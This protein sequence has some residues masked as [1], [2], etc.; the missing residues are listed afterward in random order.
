VG[1]IKSAKWAKSEWRNYPRSSKQ[2]V[3]AGS[4]GKILK[5]RLVAVPLLKVH[6][7]THGE[8]GDDL[9]GL[10]DARDDAMIATLA[11][12]PNPEHYKMPA[13]QRSFHDAAALDWLSK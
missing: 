6:A 3:S 13:G 2:V 8:N 1:K 12:C 7:G 9:R 4:G 10:D 11:E 5:A